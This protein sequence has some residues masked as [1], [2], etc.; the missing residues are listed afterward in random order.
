MAIEPVAPLPEDRGDAVPAAPEIT[1]GTVPAG[2][3]EVA[4]TQ[5]EPPPPPAPDTD[6]LTVD[7]PPP[8]PVYPPP[9]PP[10]LS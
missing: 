10:A 1:V 9:P 2:T 8:P 7:A 6:E 5:L 4:A 3:G